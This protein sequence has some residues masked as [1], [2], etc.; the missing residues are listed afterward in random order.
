MTQT[1]ETLKGDSMIRS[2]TRVRTLLGSALLAITALG[3]SSVLARESTSP[4][5]VRPA[6][7]KVADDD[8]TIW[9]F[10]TIHVLPEPVAW[11]QGVV[12]RA[13]ATSEEL[14]TEIAMDA[15]AQPQD[16]ILGRVGARTAALSGTPCRKSS[17]RP[18]R[19]PWPSLAC[20]SRRST[21]TTPGSRRSC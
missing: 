17:A 2:M 5:T 3:A 11:N 20:R 6:L 1:E 7:W 15:A 16:A 14:V 18:M 9:L 12:A 8:T 13:L 10:G 4:E 21:I 19:Q